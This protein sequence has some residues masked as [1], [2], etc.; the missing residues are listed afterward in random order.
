MRKWNLEYIGSYKKNYLPYIFEN[1]FVEGMKAI[2][3][4]GKI[5]L[6][7]FDDVYLIPAQ[8]AN[9]IQCT[10]FLVEWRNA[11]EKR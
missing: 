4:T 2:A 11:L 3:E 7:E 1:D 8:E 10:A 9:A 5:D 6:K